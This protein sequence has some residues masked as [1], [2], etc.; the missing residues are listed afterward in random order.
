[1]LMFW[2]P[3][4]AIACIASSVECT[5]SDRRC[6]ASTNST[7]HDSMRHWMTGSSMC[8]A[9]LI[10]MLCPRSARSSSSTVHVMLHSS[11]SASASLQYMRGSSEA[12]MH[13]TMCHFA[14]LRASS[15][16]FSIA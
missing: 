13:G 14:A 9:T 12:D 7:G 2:H 11:C 6:R 4:S 10:V 3:F 8:C 15:A 5:G 1:M 16:L